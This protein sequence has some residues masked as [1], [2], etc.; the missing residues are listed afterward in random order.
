MISVLLSQTHRPAQVHRRHLAVGRG[1]RG[2][3]AASQGDLA[4]WTST[5]MSAGD[6]KTAILQSNE[7]FAS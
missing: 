4:F 1:Q 7:F 2:T 5:G 3:R 6:I